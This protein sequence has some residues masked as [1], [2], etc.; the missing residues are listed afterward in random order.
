MLSRFATVG[1]AAA[2][3]LAALPASAQAIGGGS[4]VSDQGLRFTAKINVGNGARSCT[5]ALV[6]PW[7]VLTSASCLGSTATGAPAQRTTATVG[8]IDLASTAGLVLDV[9]RVVPHSGRDVALARLA[10]PAYGVPTVALASA[11]PAVGDTLVAAGYGRTRD[12]WV[13]SVLRAGEVTVDGVGAGALDVTAGGDTAI[14]KGDAG[15]PALRRAGAGYELAGLH[16]AAAQGGC[17]GETAAA[18]TAVTARVD[19]L[20]P[21]VTQTAVTPAAQQVALTATRIGLLKGDYGTLVKEGGLS[22]AWTTLLANAKQ[23]V[24]DGNRI[25]VL[26]HDGVAWVKEGATTAAFVNEYANVRQLALSGDRIGVV[27]NAGVALVKEGG[28]S[29]PWVTEY[30]GVQSMALAGDR[31]GVVTDAGAAL[32]KQGGLSAS[33]VTQY[34]GV[35]QIALSADR[36]GVVTTTGGSRVKAGGLSA[37]WTEQAPSGT[38]ALSLANDRIGLLTTDGV[39]KVKDGAPNAAFV[40]QYTNVRQLDIAAD[41]IGVV[42]LDGP[43]L[44]KDGGLSALWTTVWR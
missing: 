9:D 41:R 42:T 5:G 39:A 23:I 44:V 30:H 8:R 6:T 17:L 21:W 7:W 12:T 20:G 32:V 19:D 2:L 33:W 38:A 43:A 35:R 13:P 3:T 25:G 34:T 4:A 28:L 27:T 18:R 10:Q 15:G 24:V 16:V 26:T 1:A 14:C 29:A 31:I 22:A 37:L 11:P 36:I 40:T